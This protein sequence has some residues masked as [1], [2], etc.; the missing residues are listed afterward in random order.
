MSS[1]PPSPAPPRW[2]VA[3]VAILCAAAGAGLRSWRPWAGV[4]S[5]LPVVEVAALPGATPVLPRLST[6]SLPSLSY[7]NRLSAL[8][9]ALPDMTVAQIAPLVKDLTATCQEGGSGGGTAKSTEALLR[10]LLLRWAELDSP[11]MLT[12]LESPDYRYAQE[13]RLFAVNALAELRGLAGLTPVQEKWPGLAC[14]AAYDIL[15]RQPEQL[16]ALLPLLRMVDGW[17]GFGYDTDEFVKL[18]GPERFVQLAAATGEEGYVWSSLEALSRTEPQRAW[19]IAKSLPPGRYR[20]S[21]VETLLRGMDPRYAGPADRAAAALLFR[22]EYEAL[23]P[24]NA[25]DAHTSTYARLLAEENYDAALTWARSQPDGAM[26]RKALLGAGEC[27]PDDAAP[28]DRTRLSTEAWLADPGWPDSAPTGSFKEWYT[29]DPKAAEAWLQTVPHLS[30]RSELARAL[31]ATPGHDL[32][33]LSSSIERLDYAVDSLFPD[34]REK[35]RQEREK[36]EPRTDILPPD[37]A[38]L[39]KLTATVRNGVTDEV[40]A[41]AGTDERHFLSADAM[42][43]HM[44]RGGAEEA[45]KLFATMAPEERSLSAWYEAGR[46]KISQDAEGAAGWVASLPP[47]AERDAATTA[48]VEY[49]SGDVWTDSDGRRLFRYHMEPVT[50]TD[51]AAVF[52][53]AAGMSGGEE[54]AVYLEKAA[55]VWAMEN[56][57]AARAGIA[58]SGLPDAEKQRLLQ[59]IPEG[60]AQ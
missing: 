59:N 9:A 48:L 58:A 54:R 43:H 52:S 20:D 5:S 11:G 30:L 22:M 23:P 38:H 56:A 51:G 14:R 27:L 24:G 37:I 28:A 12:A 21:A 57:A 60:G 46:A 1:A 35:S 3:G 50:N 7:L 49:L 4:K 16:E 45:L 53:W 15:R 33:L 47:G 6:E 19:Q 32:S 34:D 44:E 40:W 8:A 41:A 17:W 29:A 31:L 55:Q 36:E 25:R 42:K 13:T 18:L 39:A 2:R 10:V 26:R